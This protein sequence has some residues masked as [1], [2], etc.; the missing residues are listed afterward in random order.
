MTEKTGHT[1]PKITPI[2]TDLKPQNSHYF[3]V[4][5][6]ISDRFGYKA[7]YNYAPTDQLSVNMY[8]SRSWKEAD[9]MLFYELFGTGVTFSR[10]NIAKLTVYKIKKI[11]FNYLNQLCYEFNK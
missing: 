9:L 1:D 8:V 11:Q 6:V 3:A 4:E 2:S 10:Q 5:P 7:G